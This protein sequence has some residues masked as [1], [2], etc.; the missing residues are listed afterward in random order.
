MARQ[1]G[2]VYVI[3]FI[4]LAGAASGVVDTTALDADASC[5]LKLDDGPCRALVPRWF[6]NFT[7]GKCEE[8]DYG[9]CDGNANNFHTKQECEDTCKFVPKKACTLEP[10]GGPCRAMIRRWHFN[11]TDGRCKKFYYGGCSG[12]DNNFETRREC[13]DSCRRTKQLKVNNYTNIIYKM[14]CEPQPYKGN[15][16]YGSKRFFYNAS[17][18]ACQDL[19]NGTCATGTNKY[20]QKSKCWIACFGHPGSNITEQKFSKHNY[21]EGETDKRKPALKKKQY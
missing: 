4:I 15:C 19:E 8:F 1:E 9:G 14:D 17:K 2:C 16:T 20:A 21:Y 13:E 5:R 6:N 12:N 11:E 7:T 18:E 3:A 10:E